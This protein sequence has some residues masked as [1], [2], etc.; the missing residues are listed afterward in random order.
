MSKILFTDKQVKKFSKN[1]WIKNIS[2]KAITYTDEFKIKLVK[3]TENLKEG[4][5]GSRYIG[6]SYDVDTEKVIRIT[7]NFATEIEL[8]KV[9]FTKVNGEKVI[10]I[11]SIKDKIKSDKNPC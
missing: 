9:P 3:E 1:K 8:D 11:D 4:D 5:D 6:I 7:S 2:N 10:N